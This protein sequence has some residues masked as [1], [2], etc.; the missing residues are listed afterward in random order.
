M[1]AL[2]NSTGIH[3]ES[4]DV[5]HLGRGIKYLELLVTQ[6]K[7]HKK[8]ATKMMPRHKIP[9]VPEPYLSLKT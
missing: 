4:L 1:D 5:Q 2:S 6:L 8:A 9:P 3:L 7:P